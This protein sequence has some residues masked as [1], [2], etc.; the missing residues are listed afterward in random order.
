MSC[1]HFVN[2]HPPLSKKQPIPFLM[3]KKLLRHTIY[4]NYHLEKISELGIVEQHLC[5]E[6]GGFPIIFTL[7]M[8]YLAVL[9]IQR[10]GVNLISHRIMLKRTPKRLLRIPGPKM[11][12]PPSTAS[13]QPLY[14]DGP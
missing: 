8:F 4:N 13:Y 11:V 1:R 5:E 2:K 7:T 12:S 9:D 10:L 14:G 6:V 3:I